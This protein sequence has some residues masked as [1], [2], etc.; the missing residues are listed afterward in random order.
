MLSYNPSFNRSLSGIAYRNTLGWLPGMNG[1]G[2]NKEQGRAARADD[3]SV[4]V[5]RFDKETGKVVGEAVARG[6]GSWLSHLIV[7]GEVVWRIE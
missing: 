2:Q 6:H 3:V 1:L 4:E 5:F 7:D